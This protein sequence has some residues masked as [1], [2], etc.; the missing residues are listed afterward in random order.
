MRYLQDSALLVIR[1]N[2]DAENDEDVQHE[3]MLVPQKAFVNSYAQPFQQLFMN[4]PI[5]LGD[6]HQKVLVDSM[7]WRSIDQSGRLLYDS[8]TKVISSVSWQNLD[9]EEVKKK[10]RD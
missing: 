7:Q 1:N 4:E 8:T 9:H 5:D 3:G 2:V 6:E 10:F